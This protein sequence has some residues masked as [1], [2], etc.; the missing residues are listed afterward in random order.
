[1]RMPEHESKLL[2]LYF[3]RLMWTKGLELEHTDMRPDKP[4]LVRPSAGNLSNW[5][6]TRRHF[7]FGA[8]MYLS[9]RARHFD[10]FHDPGSLFGF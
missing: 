1:M 4:L 6:V 3:G 10:Y 9:L 8:L 5:G 2:L 7:I